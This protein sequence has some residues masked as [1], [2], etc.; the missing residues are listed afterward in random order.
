MCGLAALFEHERHFS[1][2][3]IATIDRDLFHRGPDS[4]GSHVEPGAAL[5]FRRL[6]ILD[7]DPR[8]DQ[9]MH[10][11]S[12]RYVIIFNGEIYN[13]RALRAEL[14]QAGVSFRGDGD[15]EAVLQGYITWGEAVLDKL[16][17]MYA[18]IIWDREAK[19]ALAAR[20]PFGIKPLYLARRDGLTAFASEMRPL[21]RL[22]GTEVDPEAM[23]ELLLFRYAAGRHS[24]LKGIELI[25]GGTLVRLD[26]ASGATSERRFCDVLETLQPDDSISEQEAL[27]LIEEALVKSV[28]DHLQSDVGYAVQLSGGIDSSLVTALA[29]ERCPGRLRSYGVSLGDLP[30]DEGYYRRLVVE[31]YRPDHKE[32]E[33]TNRD[34]ADAMPRAAAHM[35]GPV[36]HFGC[37]MLMLLCDRIRETDKVVLTGEGADEFFGG[38]S[39]YGE[40]R[41][42]RKFGRIASL[43]P[44]FLWPFLQRYRGIQRYAGRD[45]AIDSQ[46]YFDTVRLQE[47]FPDYLPRPGA[48]ESAASRFR[49][50]RDRMMAA[51]QTSYL[52]SLL[53]R[54]DKMAMAA[55]VEA[56]V[57]FTHLPLA[58]AVNKIPQHLRV[59]GG[60]TKP[61][62]KQVSRKWLPDELI[63]RRKV[64]L[65]LPL[66]DWLEDP[67]GLGRY[68]DFISAADSGLGAFTEPKR[69][70]AL[71]ADFR[72]GHRD[73]V[74]VP[75]LGHLM[76]IEAWLR[77]LDDVPAPASAAA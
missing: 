52:S 58:R 49:D 4:G 45:A 5:V 40:W 65:A 46:V 70:Q 6:A 1:P 63:E 47:V 25:P 12:G 30:Q 67:K 8:S 53:M 26:L 23:A 10:D 36:P 44:G 27:A 69:L 3:L 62:L 37:T 18:L 2:E 31:R 60:V 51:D 61:L 33:L 66:A 43:V 68:L 19:V 48:R 21:R 16:E 75:L 73:S 13:Y 56:R 55:S 11:P 22:I 64:G 71:V 50:F 77:S 41:R 76:T 32:V 29:S 72:A 38:Y 20:D 54:Q 42:L 34:Y 59:P 14:G 7:P 9:P 35:E 39:R 24:N 15:T 28:E 74:Q 57:P 17:G